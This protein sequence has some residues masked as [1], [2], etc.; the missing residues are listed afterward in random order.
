MYAAYTKNGRQKPL[1][2]ACRSAVWHILMQNYFF[3]PYSCLFVYAFLS[4]QTFVHSEYRM[5]LSYL[6]IT[7]FD[8]V[9]PAELYFTA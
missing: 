8:A 7:T 6:M 2:F 1:T 4:M 9:A 3:I 5:L